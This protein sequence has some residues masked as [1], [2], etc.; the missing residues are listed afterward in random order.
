MAS[1]ELLDAS[2]QPHGVIVQVDSGAVISL[3]RRSVADELGLS[4]HNGQRVG[5]GGVGGGEVQ[6][7]VHVLSARFDDNVA[8]D[9]PFAISASEAVPNLLGR[10]GVFDRLSIHF[11]SVRKLTRIV[12]P[13]SRSGRR[14][15]RASQ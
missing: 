1:I 15:R 5:L 8:L 2:G 7:H 6:A 14:R 3:L 12:L 4:L 13:R 11:D 10:F 9:L